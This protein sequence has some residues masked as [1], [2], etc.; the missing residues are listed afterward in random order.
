MNAFGL[1]Q[2]EVIGRSVAELFGDEFFESTI[3]SHAE[4]CLR[5]K[6]VRYQDWFEFPSTLILGMGTYPS[7]F[8]F[9]GDR[10]NHQ[11]TLNLHL[12]ESGQMSDRRNQ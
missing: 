10:S 5:G 4:D 1:N 3:R 12:H 6:D 8:L 7:T 11:R 2:S 9:Y